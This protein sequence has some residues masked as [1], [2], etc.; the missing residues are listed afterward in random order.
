MLG[1]EDGLTAL[2]Y[3]TAVACCPCPS[4]VEANQKL[5]NPLPMYSRDSYIRIG[6]NSPQQITAAITHWRSKRGQASNA[7]SA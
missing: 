2:R 7:R 6:G 5:K 1:M 4:S 3:P